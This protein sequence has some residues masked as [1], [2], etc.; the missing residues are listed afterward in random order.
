MRC[1]L[2]GL[3]LIAVG[4]ATSGVA[5]EAAARKPRLELRATARPVLTPV[6]V[7]AVAELV[8]GEDLEDF[9]C[10]GLEWD[11]GDGNRSFRESDCDPWEPGAEVGRLFTARHVY[12]HPGVY[13][14]RIRLRRADGDVAVARTQVRVMGRRQ[15]RMRIW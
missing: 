3:A 7:M 10:V 11:W 9:Y 5:G 6:P 2:F 1:R 13:E 4:L 14:V 8:G 15:A 12:H